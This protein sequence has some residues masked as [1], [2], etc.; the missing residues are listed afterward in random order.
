MELYKSTFTFTFTFMQA[1]GCVL[2]VP[3]DVSNMRTKVNTQCLIDDCN[4]YH[5]EERLV[6]VR[7]LNFI[8]VTSHIS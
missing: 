1:I 2:F 5:S 8:S 4:I 3:F 7:V 6:I